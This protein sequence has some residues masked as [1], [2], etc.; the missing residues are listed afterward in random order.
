MRISDWSSDV[1]S[2]DL[3]AVEPDGARRGRD[4]FGPLRLDLPLIAPQPRLMGVGDV[5]MRAVGRQADAVI[6]HR[7]TVD[8][9]DRRPV[10]QGAEQPACGADAVRAFAQATGRA[11]VRERVWTYVWI[12]VVAVAFKKTHNM[13]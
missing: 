9:R 5:D 3:K 4:P 1:C 13:S 10:G 11:S 7:M 2:S 8:R 12:S 6:G